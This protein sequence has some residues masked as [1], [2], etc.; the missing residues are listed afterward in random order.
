[1]TKT[2]DIVDRITAYEAGDLQGEETVELFQELIDSG[3]VWKVQGSYGRTAM[4]L[5]EAGLCTLGEEGHY[6]YWG[7]YVPSKYEVQPGTPGSQ[8][9]VDE[10]AQQQ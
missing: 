2:T 3:L 1:M 10:R 6:D 7:H 8:E 4:D 5:I 9:Y